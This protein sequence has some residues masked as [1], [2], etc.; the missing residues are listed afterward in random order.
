MKEHAFRFGRARH[1]VGIAGLPR[2]ASAEVAVVM[3]N[4]GFVHRIG[5]FRLYAEMTR[6]LNAI[7]Y[8]T[9]RFDLSTLGDSGAS[10][11][12]QTRI[13]QV[14]ADVADAMQLLTEKAGC[15]RF[16]VI[17]LCSGAENAHRAACIGAGIVGAVFLDGYIYRTTGFLL[18]H[19][20]PRLL[21]VKRLRGYVARVLR[22]NM[23]KDS[24]PRFGVEYPPKAEVIADLSGM[25]SR[26]LKLFFLYS[27][28]VS[29]YINHQRQFR[30]CFGR[31][32][33][34]PQISV[35]LLDDTDHTYILRG[36]RERLFDAVENWLERNFPIEA[37][38]RNLS[39]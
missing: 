19:Y 38:A 26:G 30:E 9:L 10:G 3:L 12:S 39:S 33:Y 16:I 27:G 13:Q 7:G 5:P 31:L 28:G 25:L 15:S 14:R 24:S 29:H 2:D 37:I 21:S 32:A 6:R 36:D 34:H 11:E 22:T 18:R 35:M 8:P 17:G 20:L 4:A 1:L 23:K